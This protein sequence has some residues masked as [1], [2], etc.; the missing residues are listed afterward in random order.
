M[1]FAIPLS[2][3]AEAVNT[4]TTEIETVS[5]QPREIDQTKTMRLTSSYQYVLGDDNWWGDRTVR[6]YFEKSEG[7]TQISVY[8]LD[9]N[10]NRVGTKLISL[11]SNA[12]FR[13]PEDG[14]SF[15][16]YASK[17]DGKDGNATIR[18]TL[19]K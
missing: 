16:V 10:G 11:G 18:V 7:P 5:V 1:L 14:G 12:S 19:K 15:S 3:S 17:S 13:L 4:N 6:V 2:A 9:K 8:V